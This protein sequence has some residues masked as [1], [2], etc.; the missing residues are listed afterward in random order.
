MPKQ[1]LFVAQGPIEWSSSRYRAWW[2]AKYADWANCKLLS[3]IAKSDFENYEV[4]VWPKPCAHDQRMAVA[5]FKHAGARVIWDICDPMWWLAPTDT[6]AMLAL[7]DDV[8]VSSDGLAR[9]LDAALGVEAHVIN[10]RMC[11]D[12][13]PA[14]K[15]YKDA[16]APVLIWYGWGWN[17][18]ASLSAAALGLQSL[19]ARGVRF[20]LRVLDDGPPGGVGFDGI[21]TQYHKWRI[22]TFHEEL[23]SA[24]VALCPGY[25]GPW[26]RMKSNNK[27][28]SAW[29]A[30]LPVAR[31]DTINDVEC[32]VRLLTDV[33][34]R[35]QEGAAN[36]AVAERE[37]DVQT[38]V[39]EWE[40]II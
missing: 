11:A 25:A 14:P 26:G 32:A 1:T 28:V 13:H 29:W 17:R 37:Y 3:E 18:V 35:A 30:G 16:I 15:E 20:N 39:Y 12:F 31:L 24:D 7:V 40:Q 5:K 34:E 10:D 33:G 6:S 4:V 2:L 22:G 38:S 19:V 27:E 23:I 21:D 8:V 36:R 9:D